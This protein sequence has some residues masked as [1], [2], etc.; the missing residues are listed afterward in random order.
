MVNHPEQQGDPFLGHYTLVKNSQIHINKL[1]HEQTE[2][3]SKFLKPQGVYTDVFIS[4]LISI[5]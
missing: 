2:H 4:L 3:Y 5:Q 1:K